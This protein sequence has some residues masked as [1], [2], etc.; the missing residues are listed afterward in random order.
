M[1]NK[2]SVFI[3]TFTFVKTSANKIRVVKLE[4]QISEM[5]QHSESSNIKM[6]SSVRDRSRFTQIARTIVATLLAAPEN[7]SSLQ[8][9][10]FLVHRKDLKLAKPVIP[11]SATPVTIAVTG[12]TFPL[13]TTS[14]PTL[15]DY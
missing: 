7:L 10:R 1:R 5:K 6:F 12:N 8:N 11:G 2:Y 4:W 15:Y 14:L 3:L 9:G 13:L